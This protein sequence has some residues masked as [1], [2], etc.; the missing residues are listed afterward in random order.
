MWVGFVSKKGS[1]FLP[2]RRLLNERLARAAGGGE[3]LSLSS[4]STSS[5]S[6]TEVS[7]LLPRMKEPQSQLGN[8]GSAVALP[9]CFLLRSEQ[10]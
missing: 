3:M 10:G 7:A 4:S 9:P 5:A 8:G 6:G 1:A 2:L